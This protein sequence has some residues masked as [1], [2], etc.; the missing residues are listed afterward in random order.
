MEP[1]TSGIVP[2]LGSFIPRL[3]YSFCMWKNTL[4]SGASE[5]GSFVNMHTVESV[6]LRPQTAVAV[7]CQ[8]LADPVVS[9][10]HKTALPGF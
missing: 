6:L 8:L 10:I 1:S 5:R 3:Q 9:F 7:L 2:G 4:D